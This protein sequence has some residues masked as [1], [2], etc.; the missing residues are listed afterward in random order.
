MWILNR[1]MFLLLLDIKAKAKQ[2][3]LKVK[4][5]Q[6]LTLKCF[7]ITRVQINMVWNNSWTIINCILITLCL[8]NGGT[9]QFSRWSRNLVPGTHNS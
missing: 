6:T 2:I 3:S 9:C 7:L 4:L 5:L 1:N 8:L